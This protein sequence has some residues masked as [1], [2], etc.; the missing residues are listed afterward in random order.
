LAQGSPGAPMP[1][2]G[3]VEALL[4]AEEARKPK[5]PP[6][7][8]DQKVAYRMLTQLGLKPDIA[9]GEV[10]VR[11]PEMPELFATLV[12]L[13]YKPKK[14]PEGA[15]VVVPPT[16]KAPSAIA[17]RSVA[18]KL[19]RGENTVER[20]EK[21]ASVPRP[22]PKPQRPKP[23]AAPYFPETDD[24]MR[25]NAKE[26]AKEQAKSI[27]RLTRGK[28]PMA[29]DLVDIPAKPSRVLK[30][31]EADALYARL[32]KPAKR[33]DQP[34]PEKETADLPPEAEET[35]V[36]LADPEEADRLAAIAAAERNAA[37][38]RR[39][40]ALERLH[41]G[42]GAKKKEMQPFDA[43]SAVLGSLGFKKDVEGRIAL[44]KD[45]PDLKTAPDPARLRNLA[46]PRKSKAQPTRASG[47]FDVAPDFIE[48]K[49]NRGDWTE[50]NADQDTDEAKAKRTVDVKRM[51]ELAKPA[52]VARPKSAERFCPGAWRSPDDLPGEDPAAVYCENLPHRL[53]PNRPRAVQS[54]MPAKPTWEAQQAAM[55]RLVARKDKHAAEEVREIARAKSS[56]LA[57]AARGLV[58]GEVSAELR[59]YFEEVLWTALS[60]AREFG[61]VRELAE[62]VG[63]CRPAAPEGAP[64]FAPAACVQARI[65]AEFPALAAEIAKWR[66]PEEEAAAISRLR[67]GRD[68]LLRLAQR[69]RK[70]RM[71]RV[72]EEPEAKAEGPRRSSMSHWT[73]DLQELRTPRPGAGPPTGLVGYELA[74]GR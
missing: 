55:R 35:A 26:Q 70:P 54:V 10:E 40:E 38:E 21:T 39:R 46:Q 23:E 15:V 9:G 42:I 59:S 19:L 61:A 36:A 74:K 71:Q 3:L 6:A 12:A 18:D 14:H 48:G 16:R 29:E 44:D 62:T 5:P 25:E 22:R 69:A 41:T 28:L 66:V 52:R 53:D 65:D 68:A 32:S 33:G 24:W 31:D 49:R 4:D 51:E 7:G 45:L 64:V 50:S 13:G 67:S 30:S 56:D 60:L 57:T 63:W 27:E 58:A 2:F 47:E 17:Q 34:E 20:E 72:E 43:D 11:Q 73:P 8:L 1:G 37:A